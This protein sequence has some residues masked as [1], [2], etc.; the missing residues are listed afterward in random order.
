MVC[1]W[2]ASH[3]K[4]VEDPTSDIILWKS[5]KYME[6]WRGALLLYEFNYISKLKDKVSDID[7]HSLNTFTER[8]LYSYKKNCCYSLVNLFSFFHFH[9]AFCSYLFS[10]LQTSFYYFDSDISFNNAFQPIKGH[11]LDLCLM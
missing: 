8:I 10:L 1:V 5:H 3:T 2:R 11:L 4:K 9:S 6:S 7:E